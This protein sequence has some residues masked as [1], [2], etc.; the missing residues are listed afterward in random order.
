MITSIDY[1]CSNPEENRDWGFEMTAIS[2]SSKFGRLIRD[3]KG[4]FAMI[5]AVAIPMVIAAASFGVDTTNAFS[6]K[7]HLQDAADAAALA[8]SSEAVKDE[9]MTEAKAKAF[10]L[11]FVN[12]QLKQYTP[13]F[14]ELT[15]KPEITVTPVKD[16]NRTVWKV[17]VKLT[18]SQS[19]TP[20]ARFLG[21]DK[22]SVN[23]RGSSES[24]RGN[25]G[26][27]SMALVLDQSGSMGW[28]L[29]GVQKIKVL[30]E[31][32]DGLIDQFDDVDPKS[33]YVR[34]G[35]VTYSNKKNA[36]SSPTWKRKST[37]AFVNSLR[38]S[39]GT[40]S[41][42]AFEWGVDTIGDEAELKA[43]KDMNGQ[44]PKRF[45]VFMTDGANNYA[46]SDYDTLKLCAQAKAEGIEVFSVAFA[47]PAQGQNLLM[48]CATKPDNYFDAKNSA[49]LIKAFE[50]IGK[51]TA[52]SMTRLT[53]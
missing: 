22:I 44:T 1:C 11:D 30:K 18:G 46:S 5:G 53:G 43:H 39:G 19:T 17:S 25:Q 38:A 33:E 15:V 35:A 9:N 45:I 27:L 7:S 40:N 26:A 29:N 20:M 41:T 8:T 12:G 31:A 24:A 50:E 47:A 4:N 28:Y 2:L 13:L 52:D 34:I 14:A 36:N 16:A 3:T 49:E 6:M 21:K 37:R 42:E 32:V 51:K 48:K 10:A 23:V